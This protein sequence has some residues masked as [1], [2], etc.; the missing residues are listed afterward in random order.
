MRNTGRFVVM[1]VAL[2]GIGAGLWC[3]GKIKERRD[4]G[5]PSADVAHGHLLLHAAEGLERPRA[6]GAPGRAVT[7]PP[8]IRPVRPVVAPPRVI[9]VRP[10]FRPPIFIP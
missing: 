5:Q 4:A 6:S 9:P 1:T 10:V 2:L 7:E 8:M 3:W